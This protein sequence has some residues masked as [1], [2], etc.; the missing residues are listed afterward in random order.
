MIVMKKC[1]NTL[2][3][4]NSKFCILNR[5][6]IIFRTRISHVKRKLA[7]KFKWEY[8]NNVEVQRK[9]IRKFEPNEPKTSTTEVKI[10]EIHC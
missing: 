8:E 2:T 6:K 5:F 3:D 10:I 7:I 4:D 1:I 9:F